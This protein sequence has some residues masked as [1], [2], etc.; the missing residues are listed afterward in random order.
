MFSDNINVC[1]VEGKCGQAAAFGRSRIMHVGARC[2]DY[3]C[4]S[5]LF[6]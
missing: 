3:G 2:R 5:W 1:P 6:G 4:E